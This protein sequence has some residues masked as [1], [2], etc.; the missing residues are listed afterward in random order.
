MDNEFAGLTLNHVNFEE[1]K[2]WLEDYYNQYVFKFIF[3]NGEKSRLK[4]IKEYKKHSFHIHNQEKIDSP[5]IILK[6]NIIKNHRVINS[7]Y[8]DDVEAI[9][10]YAK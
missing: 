2:K 6:D 7:F 10:V 5:R 1:S 3:K 8:L 4:E 9:E